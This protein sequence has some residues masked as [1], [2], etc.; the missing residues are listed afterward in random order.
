MRYL[1]SM[2]ITP[3]VA[4]G[5]CILSVFY[6]LNFTERRG[7]G[8]AYYF[9]MSLIVAATICIAVKGRS[10][11]ELYRQRTDE[12]KRSAAFRFVDGIASYFMRTLFTAMILTLVYEYVG[13]LA[14]S[15]SRVATPIS[16]E[17]FHWPKT[18]E[19]G[20]YR[21]YSDISHTCR[22]DR[23][24]M[25]SSSKYGFRRRGRGQDYY[26]RVGNDSISF[27]CKGSDPHEKCKVHA[28]E[29]DVFIVLGPEEPID[30]PMTA[31][32]KNADAHHLSESIEL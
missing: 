12:K 11:R 30:T 13:I 5:A 7:I 25:G 31:Q 19:R 9:V 18:C 24:Y 17:A 4:A 21:F 8:L 27:R 26:Y 1:L 28:I 3:P 22:V 2:L 16:A 32:P 14:D 20:T 6:F 23:Y 10:E 15:N 29:H